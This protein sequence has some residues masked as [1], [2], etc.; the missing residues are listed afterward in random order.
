MSTK[1]FISLVVGVLVLGAAIGGSFLGGLAIGKNQEAEA[2][3]AIA[4]VPQAPTLAAQPSEETAGQNFA[5]LRERLQ[6]GDL[7]DEELAELR[8]Q[9]QDGGAGGFGGG[10]PRGGFGGGGGQG[11]LTGTIE[12]IDGTTVTLNTSE[13]TLRVAIT[14]ETTIQKTVQVTAG[15]LVEGERLTVVGTPGED[16]IVEATFM[17][18]VPEGQAGGFGGSG[19]G[20]FGGGGFG[21]GG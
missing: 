5:Q 12:S 10:R 6:S 14:D 17:I 9:F 3:A 4:P 19:G 20:G 16:G 11:G 1:V 15:D 7:S 8:Q 18:V 21:G 13:G 2:A